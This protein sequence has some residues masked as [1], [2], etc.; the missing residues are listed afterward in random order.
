MLKPHLPGD[1]TK[2]FSAL[3]KYSLLLIIHTERAVAWVIQKSLWFGFRI[4]ALF[5]TLRQVCGPE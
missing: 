3:S 2:S 1:Y 4:Y 5:L